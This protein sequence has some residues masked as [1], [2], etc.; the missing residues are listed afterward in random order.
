MGF[1]VIVR[2]VWVVQHAGLVRYISY[3]YGNDN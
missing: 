1:G 2:V 3:M